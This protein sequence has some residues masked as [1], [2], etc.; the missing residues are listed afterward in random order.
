MTFVVPTEAAF[1]RAVEMADSAIAAQT[2]RR[3]EFAKA[4]DTGLLYRHDDTK[5]RRVDGAVNALSV[6]S[7]PTNAA[8]TVAEINALAIALQTRYGGGEIYLPNS[9]GW[10]VQGAVN[11]GHFAA[12]ANRVPALILRKGISFR[13]SGTELMFTGTVPQPVFGN[14]PPCVIP[15]LTWVADANATP[16]AL[17]T[18]DVTAGD[19]TFTVDTSAAFTVGAQVLMT[20]GQNPN[21]TPE[22][23]WLG[24]GHV[25][26]KTGTTL[27]LDIPADIPVQVSAQ[28]T[29]TTLAGSTYHFLAAGSG[30]VDNP[31]AHSIWLCDEIADGDVEGFVGKSQ[32][33]THHPLLMTQF[34]LSRGITVSSC[35]SDNAGAFNA[36]SSLDVAMRDIA[37][38]R[39]DTWGS[40]SLGRVLVLGSGLRNFTADNVSG[41]N[42]ESTAVF[43]E[44]Y[45]RG[46]DI[47]RL[48]LLNS[49]ATR[50]NSLALLFS[51]GNAPFEIRGLEVGGNGCPLSSNS[52]DTNDSTAPIRISGEARIRNTTPM[53][54]VAPR[55]FRDGVTLDNA[56]IYDA[57]AGATRYQPPKT[58]RKRIP[59]R[60]T[61]SVTIPLPDGLLARGHIYA[62]TVTGLTA[63]AFQGLPVSA[64][65]ALNYLYPGQSAAIP[66]SVC[67]IGQ[68]SGGATVQWGSYRTGKQLKVTADATMTPGQFLIVELT[69]LSP[70]AAEAP[71]PPGVAT[72]L[73]ADVMQAR[74]DAYAAQTIY[75]QATLSN[76]TTETVLASFTVPAASVTPGTILRIAAGGSNDF[77]ATSGTLTYRLRWASVTGTAIGTLA[78]ATQ[79]AAGTAKVWTWTETGAFRTRGS[80]AVLAYHGLFRAE[81]PSTAAQA[82]INAAPTLD[83]SID[84]QLVLTAQWATADV[85]NIARV[86]HAS[87]QIIGAPL[88]G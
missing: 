69:Y 63:C 42:F 80:A 30:G 65:S 17:I 35:R 5:W 77:I 12:N 66:S 22:T 11:D 88:A 1:L 14:R 53:W 43:V 20:L 87:L 86:D 16:R 62:S 34:V 18:A 31:I 72:S 57:P 38:T 81:A 37:V 70:E 52:T 76:S 50:D 51:Q 39:S 32:D 10:Q 27:T 9:V 8:T 64:V 54:S 46:V 71:A 2:G 13:G 84:Q 25:T 60:P 24:F 83:A 79:A 19:T 55:L 41:E 44:S 47:R 78:M 73:D 59:L 67:T 33:S 15:P 48:R 4:T 68:P 58:W 45:A 49:S 74:Q 6:V 61:M 21:D 26:A 75:A 3:G 56:L 40:V 7:D 36:H 29:A 85:G 82:A 23:Q 28:T